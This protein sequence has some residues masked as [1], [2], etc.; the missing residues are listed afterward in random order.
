MIIPAYL[1]GYILALIV[2]NLKINVE[3]D[4]VETTLNVIKR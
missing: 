2:K 4:R 1:L 3:Q